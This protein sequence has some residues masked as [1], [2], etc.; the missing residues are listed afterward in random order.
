MLISCRNR[1]QVARGFESFCLDMN[2][3]EEL[4]KAFKMDLNSLPDG[5]VKVQVGTD[6]FDLN[7][8]KGAFYI[9]V[10]NGK[11]VRDVDKEEYDRTRL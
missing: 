3:F 6:V 4:E 7:P 9:E 11:K 2:V 8:D 5:I 1:S 10:K